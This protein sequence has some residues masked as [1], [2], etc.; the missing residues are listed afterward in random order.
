MKRILP[1]DTVRIPEQAECVFRGKLF[2]VYQWQQQLFDGTYATFEMLRR[3][4]TVVTLLCDGD[5]VLCVQDEQPNREGRLALPGGRVDDHDASWEAAARRELREETGLSCEH[6]RLLSVRQPAAKLEWFTAL[7]L[8][9]D[10]SDRTR[11]QLD[12]GEKI[13][14]EWRDYTSLRAEVLA[15]SEPHLEYLLPLV[16][17]AETVVELQQ[18]PAF[19]GQEIG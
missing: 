16:L 18:L 14:L 13:N 2:D 9:T 1:P 19:K 6:W 10:I 12:S 8:A 5:R 3:P 7:F 17:R 15:G 4:D 11:Q